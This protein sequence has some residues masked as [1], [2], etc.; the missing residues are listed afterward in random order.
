MNI[1]A[2]MVFWILVM[3]VVMGIAGVFQAFLGTLAL[4][5]LIVFMFIVMLGSAVIESL[6]RMWRR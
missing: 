3:A 1:I 5:F 2:P 4:F 6:T